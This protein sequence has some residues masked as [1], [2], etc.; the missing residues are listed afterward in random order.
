MLSATFACAEPAPLT[1][2]PFTSACSA[3][4]QLAARPRTRSALH[5]EITRFNRYNAVLALLRRAGGA[6]CS[7]VETP[8]K[9]Y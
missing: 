1:L 5:A 3:A 8:V 2:L 7:P 4:C 6:G 9:P